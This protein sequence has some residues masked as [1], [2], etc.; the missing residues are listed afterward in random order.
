MG[1][2]KQQVFV[3]SIIGIGIS[4]IG[5]AFIKDEKHSDDIIKLGMMV[6]ITGLTYGLLLD[7]K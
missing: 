4:A 1:L 7:T 2:T 6:S 5:S 3:V